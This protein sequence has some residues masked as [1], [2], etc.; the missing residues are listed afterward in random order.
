MPRFIHTLAL[1]AGLVTLVTGLWS[2]WG[3]LVVVKRMAIAYLGFF[4]LSSVMALVVRSVDLFEPDGTG[5]DAESAEPAGRKR[6]KAAP[7]AATGD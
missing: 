2:D 3:V 6:K 7:S 4:V 1:A 5:T